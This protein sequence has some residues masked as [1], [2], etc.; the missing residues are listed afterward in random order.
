MVARKLLENWTLWIVIDAAYV[1][2][3]IAGGHYLTA[4]NYT[5]YLIL[6]VFGFLAWRRSLTAAA[7][8]A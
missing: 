8:P 7:T 3:F 6:G 2:M 1:A 4:L 5:G